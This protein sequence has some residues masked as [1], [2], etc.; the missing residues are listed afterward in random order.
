M[1]VNV[2]VKPNSGKDSIEKEGDL[3]EISLRESAK[4][5][6]ANISMIRLL[7]RHFKVSHDKVSIISGK[8]SRKKKVRINI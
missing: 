5:N 7:S 6:K 3:Y 2:K 4:D 8:T 1:I